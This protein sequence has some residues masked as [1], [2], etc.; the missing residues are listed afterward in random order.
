METLAGKYNLS[1][2]ICLFIYLEYEE[3]KQLKKALKE[4]KKRNKNKHYASTLS[5]VHED[6]D[7]SASEDDFGPAHGRMPMAGGSVGKST[8][9]ER[10]DSGWG[11]SPTRLTGHSTPQRGK[12]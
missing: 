4:D 11:T 1:D 5:S 2:C 6:Q 10:Q 3:H 7:D 9:L 8:K 12:Y